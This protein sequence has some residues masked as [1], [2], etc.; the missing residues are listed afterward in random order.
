MRPILPLSICVPTYNGASYL[1]ECLDSILAQTFQDFEV[2]IVDDQSSD[3]SY[4][5]AQDYATRDPRFRVLRNKENLGLVGNWNQCVLLAHGEW[6]K[7]LFQ[8]DVLEAN[9]LERMVAACSPDASMVVCKRKIIFEDESKSLQ[10]GYLRFIEKCNLDRIFYGQTVISPESFSKAVFDHWLGNF[11]GEPTAVLLHRSVFSRFGLFN[12]HLIQMC[13]FEYWIRVASNTGLIY[14]PE[15]LARFRLHGKATS[16]INVSSRKFRVYLDELV[17]CHEFLFNPHYGPLRSYASR[18]EPPFNLNQ[19]FAL[20][21]RKARNTAHRA[22]KKCPHPD[23]D[24]LRELSEITKL[25]PGF[26][27]IKKIPFSLRFS[28]YL[29]KVQSFLANHSNLKVRQKD[30]RPTLIAQ[31]KGNMRMK[32]VAEL[33]SNDRIARLIAFY[34]PQYHPIPENDEWW[35]KGFTEWTNTAK[36]RPMYRGH[37]QPHVPADLGFYDLRLPEARIAQAEM[38][39]EYGIEAFCYYHYWFAGKRILERPFNEVLRTGRPDFPFCLCWANQTW[40]GVWH[41]CPDEVLIEQT[42]PGHDDYRT[43]FQSLLPAFQ[44]RRYVTVDGKPLFI[45][46]RPGSIP[47]IRHALD[48]WRNM[49]VK[50]GL[51]GLH[52]VAIING[53]QAW[54]PQQLGFD[55]TVLQDLPPLRRDGASW[56]RPLKMLHCLYQEKRGKP[57]VHNHRRVLLDLLSHE[58]SGIENYPCLLPNWDNTPRSG[59]NGLVLQGSTP[60]LFRIQ[61]KKSLEITADRSPEHRLVFIK[62]WNEWAEGNH[63]E[64][65][66][67]FGLS[68]LEVIRDEVLG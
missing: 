9:C 66:L 14:L 47:D 34:L 39:R 55:A 25:F 8:D 23:P 53:K 24:L 43:H 4:E 51:A 13:D 64:P 60:E 65:D 67:R 19:W 32:S 46:Y 40:T 63:L 37:Y 61:M 29:W 1:R 56:R 50:A 16:V 52:M 59:R 58:A 57:T 54:D 2:L 12:P 10:D 20:W 18:C 48:S 44:D 49:A 7:F 5:I 26:K 33:T 31:A 28:N 11:V 35:G 6:L 38:A 42:Y 68:Y 21:V 3:E 17:C 22:S 15:S 27:I 45:I 36:A 62:S 30:T 41:G